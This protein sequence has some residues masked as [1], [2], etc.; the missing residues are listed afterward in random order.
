MAEVARLERQLKEREYHL[1]ELIDEVVYSEKVATEASQKADKVSAERHQLLKALEDVLLY[2]SRMEQDVLLPAFSDLDSVLRRRDKMAA[3]RRDG[4]ASVSLLPSQSAQFRRLFDTLQHPSSSVAE[5]L[6][7]RQDAISLALQKNAAVATDPEDA[8]VLAEQ[9][10]ASRGRLTS[11]LADAQRHAGVAEGTSAFAGAATSSDVDALRSDLADVKSLLSQARAERDELAR[12][13]QETHDSPA[14]FKDLQAQWHAERVALQQRV[15]QLE[16]SVD[17]QRRATTAAEAQR[18][19]TEAELEQA[20]QER[21]L[22]NDE[23]RRVRAGGTVIQSSSS[24]HHLSSSDR[25]GEH[26]LRMELDRVVREH[27]AYVTQL[28]GEIAS[29]RSEAQHAQRDRAYDD[30]QT[31][32]LEQ[33]RRNNEALRRDVSRLQQQV[34]SSSRRGTGDGDD[35]LAL[36]AKVRAFE[37]TIGALNE[38]LS[39]VDRRIADVQQQQE[40]EKRRLVA[41]FDAERRQYQLEREECDALVLKMTSELEYLVRE[42]AAWRQK[43]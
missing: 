11:L 22:L 24:G 23:L 3:A 13:I 5:A 20:R 32:Q 30:A 36:E 42:N 25:S 12:R 1:A 16:Q 43:L 37:T 27:S 2:T 18:E 19:G 33:L 38:E 15:R 6:T 31:V 34:A 35:A 29:L 7:K 40:D 21:V 28:H 26:A 14:A 8:F 39:A 41:A 4:L 9:L 10:I 17:E